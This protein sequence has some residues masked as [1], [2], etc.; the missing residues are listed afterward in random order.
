VNATGHCDDP[1][2]TIC[3]NF[4]EIP[5][6]KELLNEDFDPNYSCLFNVFQLK[7]IPDFT[8]RLSAADPGMCFRNTFINRKWEWKYLQDY[9][10]I[11]DDTGTGIRRSPKLAKENRKGEENSFLFIK[12][13]K[14]VEKH[15]NHMIL[16]TAI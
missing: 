13:F 10:S 12:Y 7:C 14:A 9:H 8:I 15:G 1:T 16:S 3:D 5:N 11:E 2:G 4:S 6:Y